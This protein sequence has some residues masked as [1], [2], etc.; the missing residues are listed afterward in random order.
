MKQLSTLVDDIRPILVSEQ[1]HRRDFALA[2]L[3]ACEGPSP[4]DVGAQMVITHDRSW[5]FLSGGCIED[6]V[7]RHGREAVITGAPALLRYGEGSPWIDIRL[8]CGSAISVLVEPI[9]ADDP[10]IAALLAG[11]ASRTPILCRSD[12]H[13]RHARATRGTFVP[14]WDGT[15]FTRQ[16]EPSSRLIIIGE[17]ATALA[18]AGFAT[19]VGLEVILVS[20]NGPS[21]SPVDGIGYSRLLAADALEHIGLDMWTAVAVVTHDR[22]D[23]ERGLAHALKS[24]ACYVGAIGARA[25]LDVRRDRLRKHGV[26]EL[27]IARL[28]APIGLQGFGKSPADIAL[29]IVAEVRRVFHN[30]SAAASSEGVSTSQIAPVSSIS[31]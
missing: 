8:A 28:R 30:R 6:D 1:L 5:G 3:V 11:H 18:T 25:R 17:D 10:A 24:D 4:R 21:T 22:D 13:S 27:E 23:D 29:S 12:G 20:P 15:N 2:T 31:R 7:A 16:Y 9:A 26:N 19:H 14:C